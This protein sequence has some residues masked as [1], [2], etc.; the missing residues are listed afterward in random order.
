MRRPIDTNKLPDL[1][2]RVARML[3][4]QGT[5]IQDVVDELR[6]TDL[7]ESAIYYTIKGA[8]MCYPHVKAA[9]DEFQAS[10]NTERQPPIH[11]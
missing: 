8:A 11:D 9:L 6:N 7:S 5:T 10:V 4:V 3:Q 1:I 2:P